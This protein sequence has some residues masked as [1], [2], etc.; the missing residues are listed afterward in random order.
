MLWKKAALSALAGFVI[1][2]LISVGFILANGHG[3]PETFP[4]IFMGGFYGA[5]AM[6]SSVMYEIENWSITRATVTHFLVVF[7]LYSLL[8]RIMGWFTLDNPVFWIVVA[9]MALAYVLIW[10]L[11]YRSCKR[12]IREMNNELARIRSNTKED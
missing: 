1:G 12:R 9:V 11:Q 8:V 6:G 4:H 10:L 5:V 3:L 2:A 7:A